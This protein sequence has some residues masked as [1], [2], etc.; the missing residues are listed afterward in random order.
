[1][2]SRSNIK[3]LTAAL[4]AGVTLSACSNLYTDRRDTIAP[5]AGDAKQIN[6]VTHMVDP[7]PR[8]SA[9][10]NIAFNGEVM[11]RA[12]AR[13][14]R[15]EVTPPVSANTSSVSY[16]RAQA[17]NASGDNQ[18]QNA[19]PAP[20]QPAPSTWAGPQS[21]SSSANATAQP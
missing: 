17:Q 16:A 18:P 8:S 9:N 6:Q 15:G 13:Y 4:L 20:A 12:Y 1:M 3:A 5:W 2:S 11:Q 7:W 10:R 21:S 19:A 14:R